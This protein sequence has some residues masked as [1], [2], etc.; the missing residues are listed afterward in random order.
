[1]SGSY[2]DM[3]DLYDIFVDWPGRL[4]REMPV[5]TSRLH[6]LEVASVLDVGCGTGQH[7]RALLDTG[8]DAVGADAD[9]HMLERA[10]GIVDASRLHTWQLGDAPPKSLTD[11]SPFDA[12]TCL[13]NVWPHLIDDGVVASSVDAM[14]RLLKPGGTAIVGLK[15][16][17]I[18]RDEN[19]AYMPLLKREHDGRELFFVR[20]LDFDQPK[21]DG[22]HVCRMHMTVLSG[23]EATD[24]AIEHHRSQLM[25]VWSPD[26]LATAFSQHFDDVSVSGSP[27]DPVSAVAS[28]NVFIHAIRR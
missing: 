27:G 13:G 11:Q 16:L 23:D 1:M 22:V 9:P 25:R 17:A 14:H 21:I 18:Q 15:A 4:A 26:E 12:I 5:I 6:A 24:T 3:A 28:E 10:K 19:R 20:F 2:R 7:V 8:F